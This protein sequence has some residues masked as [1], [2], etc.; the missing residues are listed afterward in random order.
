MR[1][2]ELK[3]WI[4]RRVVLAKAQYN[5]KVFSED[6]EICGP[7]KRIQLY[8]G[9]EKISECLGLQLTENPFRTFPKKEMVYSLEYKGIE[10]IQLGTSEEVKAAEKK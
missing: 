5:T 1:N 4:D 6:I 2:E 7:S 10:F 9:I 8:V 3:A